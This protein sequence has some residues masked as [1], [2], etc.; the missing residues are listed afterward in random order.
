MY[1]QVNVQ[2][3]DCVPSHR[4][5]EIVFSKRMIKPLGIMTLGV[6]ASKFGACPKPG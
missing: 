4:M 2:P 1:Q 3:I 5:S 6:Q